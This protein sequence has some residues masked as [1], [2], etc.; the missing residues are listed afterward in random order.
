M[1]G[2]KRQVRVHLRSVQ[3]DA[4]GNTSDVE[5]DYDGILYDRP[6]ERYVI[7]EEAEP[8]VTTAY[9]IRTDEV[10]ITRRGTISTTQT[11]RQGDRNYFQAQIGEG[12]LDLQMDTEHLLAAF[13][14]DGGK[15]ELGYRL[16]SG[17]EH[18][19]DYRLTLTFQTAD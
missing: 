3:V 5:H 14:D 12:A 11:F 15:V 6:G 10:L 2:S 19:G 13:Q 4:A 1:T 8:R 17:D 7:F 16:W 9:K 18:L